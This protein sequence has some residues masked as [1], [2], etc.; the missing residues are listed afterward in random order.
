MS[1]HSINFESNLTESC[2]AAASNLWNTSGVQLT[3]PHPSQNEIQMG[4]VKQKMLNESN[5]KA[6]Y[7]IFNNLTTAISEKNLNS[8]HRAMAMQ[9]IDALT[10]FD[11]LLPVSTVTHFLQALISDSL[12]ERKLAWSVISK[13]LKQL[14]QKCIK[15]SFFVEN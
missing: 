12:R 5:L 9:F 3:S 13:C 14:K 4:L 6:Y 1:Y 10:H 11:Y 8:R 2:L 15:V 7:E